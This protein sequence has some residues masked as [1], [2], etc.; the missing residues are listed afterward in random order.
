MTPMLVRLQ[1]IW[2]TYFVYS[3][4]EKEFSFLVIGTWHTYWIYIREFN[5]LFSVD[6]VKFFPHLYSVE[7]GH[8]YQMYTLDSRY[9]E[10]I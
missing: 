3:E 4:T 10:Q 1:H 5:F 8:M 2:G 7:V 6:M 9:L